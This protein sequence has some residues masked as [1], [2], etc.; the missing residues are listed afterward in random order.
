MSD[1]RSEKALNVLLY[2][3]GKLRRKGNL[4]WILKAIYFADKKHLQRYGRQIFQQDHMKL[5]WGNVPTYTYDIVSHVRGTK[6]QPHMPKNVKN[7]IKVD[8]TNTVTPIEKPE[9]RY[10]SASELKCL[11]S[12]IDA[13]KSLDFEQLKN[14]S[15][16]DPV[17]KKAKLKHYIPIED[18]VATFSNAEELLEYIKNPHPG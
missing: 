18:I 13:V 17:F 14:F 6:L 10:F 3:A 11:N 15:H 8:E 2:V 12:A 5:D 9:M 16:R 7:R 4:Y 1:L